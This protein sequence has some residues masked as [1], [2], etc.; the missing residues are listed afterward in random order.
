VH[1]MLTVVCKVSLLE[2]T[3]RLSICIL[4]VCHVHHLAVIYYLFKVSALPVNTRKLRGSFDVRRY[5]K[6]K[7]HKT[8]RIQDTQGKRCHRQ[9]ERQL[10]TLEPSMFTVH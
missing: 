5:K 2:A 4:F 9:G 3:R 1:S 10:E 7:A 8:V 6:L